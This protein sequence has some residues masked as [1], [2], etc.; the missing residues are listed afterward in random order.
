MQNFHR[1]VLSAV[2]GCGLAAGAAPLAAQEAE[3]TPAPRPA[4]TCSHDRSGLTLPATLAGFARTDSKQ[5]DEDGYNIGIGFRDPATGSWADL[6]IY[7]AAPASVAVWGDRAAA[8][9]FV[10]PM[11]GD[12]DV[13]AIKVSR[14]TPPGGAGE[15]SGLRIVTP[16]KGDLTASGLALWLHDGW[17][18]KLRMSS[19]TLDAA[20]LE[21]RM[22]QFISLVAL[23]GAT[24]PAPAF[25]EIQ[26]CKAP[27]T[28]GKK[29]RLVKLDMM[30]SLMIGAMLGVAR[31]KEAQA[32]AGEE[33]VWCRDAASQPQYGI[34]RR[35]GQA[36]F[37]MI[38]LGDTGTS[39]SVGA[40][41]MGPLMKPSKGFLVTQSNGV[42][43]AAY[44]PFDKLPAPQQV[45]GLPGNVAPVF[46]AGLLE[47]N[48]GTTINVPS[49]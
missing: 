26:D 41:D 11:L 13:N 30:G 33:A 7:R 40:Y 8:G 10:N 15:K 49:K 35:E 29:A 9:M 48:K 24:R 38:A 39:L 21:T 2:L 25:A 32:P 19:R 20:A 22:A 31:D 37:Y 17:L 43:D 23:P 28:P 34:Y 16:T 44:P 36:D 46:S 4:A 47:E 3:A 1:F 14:F 27:M 5:F 42:T 45:L 12:V 6:F 18:V